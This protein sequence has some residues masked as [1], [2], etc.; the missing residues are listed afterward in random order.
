MAKDFK[1]SLTVNLKGVYCTEITS[2]EIGDDIVIPMVD[3][4]DMGTVRLT[5][6]LKDFDNQDVAITI[7]LVEEVE[8]VSISE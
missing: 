8:Q 3:I 6:I 4:L 1:K 2:D 7:K 5:D